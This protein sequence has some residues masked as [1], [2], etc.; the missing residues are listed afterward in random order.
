M[1]TPSEELLAK[2]PG[3]VFGQATL[4]QSEGYGLLFDARFLHHSA[5]Y[6][7]TDICCYVMIHTDN[8]GV[9]MRINNQLSYT[10]NYLYNT[11][12]PDWDLIVQLAITLCTYVKNLSI[13]HIK[14]HQ[15]DDTPEEDLDLPAWLNISA[16]RLVTQYRTQHRQTCLQVPRV[17]V[18]KVQVMTPCGVVTSHY[19]KQLQD[20][21][22]TPALCS[23]L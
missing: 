17:A 11:L 21:T 16:N 10:H 12:K 19:M 14:G 6:T 20:I 4:F 9:V 13:S 2:H 3:P 1:V 7:Q 23:Y 22:T 15:D 5:V 18:N 8:K